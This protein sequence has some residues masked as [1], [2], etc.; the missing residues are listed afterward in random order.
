MYAGFLASLLIYEGAVVLP[1][2][3]G[4][5]FW[6]LSKARPRQAILHLGILV[7]VLLAYVSAW[8]WFFGF[9]IT[10]FPVESS[11]WG[12][13][14]SFRQVIVKTLHGSLRPMVAPVYVGVLAVVLQRPRGRKLAQLSLGWSF[15]GYLPFFIVRGYAD[16]FA[17]LSSAGTALALA[18]GIVAIYRSRFKSLGLL[19]AIGLPAFYAIGMQH[20]IAMWKEAGAIAFRIPREIK[21]LAPNPKPGSTLVLLNVPKTYKHALVYLTGLERAVTLQYPGVQF[22]LKRQLIGQTPEKAIIVEY[23]NGHMRGAN[24]SR[25]QEC[26]LISTR[27]AVGWSHCRWRPIPRRE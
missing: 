14:G 5:L 11:V 4:L 6:R 22:Q 26:G 19:L 27:R 21:A 7:F 2:L 20:R 1:L 15:L 12:A 17:Y 25:K 8:N 13:T 18:S 3:A 23:S 24:L 10:R 9:H 16:R